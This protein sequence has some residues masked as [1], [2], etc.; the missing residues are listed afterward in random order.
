MGAQGLFGPDTMTW[1]INREGVLLLGGG[2]ALI[3]QVAHPLVA[4]G[5]SQHS[6]YREDPWGRLYRT[7]DVTTEIVFGSSGQSQAA[8]ER[9]WNRHGLVKG[10]SE[11]DGGRFPA[12]T[13]YRAHDPE[14][15]MWVHATLVDSSLLVYD[16]YVRRLSRRERERYYDEQKL[17]GERFGIPLDHQPRTLSDFERLFA[18]TVESEL[19]VTDTLRDV[20]DVVLRPAL[21][22][23]VRPLGYPLFQALN[24][25]TVGM[26][27][28]RLREELGLPWGPGRERML[29]A[30]HALLRNLLPLVPAVAR[31][32]PRARSADRRLRRGEPLAA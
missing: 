23:A 22:L 5:V 13:P 9:L 4:A 14:L 30:S 7:L 3:L 24:L 16:R 11:E 15:L 19:A 17:L 32:F 1:R 10:Q 12:G 29:G 18:R 21:P 28:P 6:N 31:E 26:L 20:T 27:P 8:A 25:A 2:R